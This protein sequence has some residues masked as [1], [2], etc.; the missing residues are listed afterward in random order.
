[1]DTKGATPASNG[2]ATTLHVPLASASAADTALP[3][4]H[5]G[6]AHPW[7]VLVAILLIVAA[8]AWTL[9]RQNRG[10]AGKR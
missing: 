2:T 9:L 4:S 7:S 5:F 3:P 6:N 10:G 8:V 1:M